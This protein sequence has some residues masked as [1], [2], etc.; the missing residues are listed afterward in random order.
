MP[1]SHYL[2]Y[3]YDKC[4]NFSIRQAKQYIEDLETLGTEIDEEKNQVAGE[5]A[6]ISKDGSKVVILAVPTN[7]ELAIARET[8][9]IVEN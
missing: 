5:E 4:P 7:E 9:V 3:I 2:G 1:E 8:K 6:I